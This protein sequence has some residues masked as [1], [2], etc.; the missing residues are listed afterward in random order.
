MG[1][2]T[3]LHLID[4]QVAPQYR[5]A[6][7]RSINKQRLGK[8][9]DLAEIFSCID[10][11]SADTLEFVRKRLPMPSESE[12]ADEEGFVLTA[13]GKW[14]ESERFA[15][16]LCRNHFEGSV[17]EHSREGDGAAWGWEFRNGQIRNLELRPRGKWERP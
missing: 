11:T 14:Y 16:W 4:L 3:I 5:A 7:E 6:I 10:F 2:E 17:I 15:E 13:A 9:K 8:N 1:Y 12:L